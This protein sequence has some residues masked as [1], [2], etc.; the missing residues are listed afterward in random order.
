MVLRNASD[1][2]AGGLGSLSGGVFYMGI[3]ALG[4]F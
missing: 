4:A 3:D 2:T 1:A